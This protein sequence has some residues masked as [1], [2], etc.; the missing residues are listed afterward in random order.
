MG[1]REGDLH[2]VVLKDISIDEFEPKTGE[3]KEVVVIAYYVTEQPAGKDLY[4]FI[5][6]SKYEVRDV[7]VS[8]NPD[9]DGRY[10]VFVELDRNAELLELIR[11]IT[12]DIERITGK[13]RWQ[14]TSHLTDET[15]HIS[16]VD[17]DN[18]VITDPNKYMTRK[19]F[20]KSQ[21]DELIEPVE[22]PMEEDTSNIEQFMAAAIAQ[23]V[24]LSEGYINIIH[25]GTTAKLEVVG[26]GNPDLVMETAGIQHD[27]IM[28]TDHNMRRFN[29]MIT[30]LRGVSIKDFVVIYNP[31]NEENI[32][33]T[34]KCSI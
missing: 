34:K 3:V 29:D 21:A 12:K 6:N 8:P 31:H 23:K 22:D 11:N 16:S 19:E 9:E 30:P 27:A 2:D 1:L 25:R 13:L 33:V 24:S 18:Y 7:E 5:N 10:L 32:L 4:T 17:L 26:F 20:D 14:A 28:E 15:F